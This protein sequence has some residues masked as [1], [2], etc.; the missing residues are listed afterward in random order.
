MSKP[1]LFIVGAPKCGTTSLY[2]YLSEH[3][4]IKMSTPKEPGYFASDFPGSWMVKDKDEYLSLFKGKEK[5]K[6]D[7]STVY[8]YSETALKNIKKF[9]KNAK[10]VVML[11]N[12]VDLVHSFHSQL[13]TNLDED[14]PDFEKAW[15]LQEV[16]RKGKKIPKKSRTPALLQYK[17]VGSLGKQV[18][19]LLKIFPRKQI[20]FI[21]LSDFSESP[22]RVYRDVLR[23]LELKD[24]GRSDF[25]S[26]NK[27]KVYRSYLLGK[28]FQR[29]S[30]VIRKIY[31]ALKKRFK[32]VD[33]IMRSLRKMNTVEADREKIDLEFRKKLVSEFKEDV[34]LL[35]RCLRSDLTGFLK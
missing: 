17:K 6:G 28:L 1:N 27:N 11:R 23:F 16:R 35:K 20:K 26:R 24:D 10:I 21:L 5:V 30:G 14:Q 34:Q 4:D 18:S 8:L 15:K 25:E 29:P 2:R 33:K 19:E 13:Y 32:I 22:G 3:P 7:A 9:D 12:P 31:H